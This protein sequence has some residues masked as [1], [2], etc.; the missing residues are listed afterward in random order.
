MT[1]DR[2]VAQVERRVGLADHAVAREGVIVTLG[3]GS[4]VAIVLHDARARVGG[5]AHVLLPDPSLSRDG[6]NDARFPCTAV[7]LLLSEMRRLGTR[8]GVTARLVGG[9]SM[10]RSILASTGLNVG[11]RNVVA[12]RLALEAAGVPLLAEDVGG[13]H[14]RSVVFDVASGRVTVRSLRAGE[15]EL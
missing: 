13:E 14:G 9:A 12:A 6:T 15:R 2:G 5:L 4:C 8:D 1:P 7:P 3:L 10:F 11:E